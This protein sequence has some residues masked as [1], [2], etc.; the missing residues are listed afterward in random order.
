MA[1]KGQ[2]PP[3][4]DL[5]RERIP[6]AADQIGRL[7]LLGRHRGPAALLEGFVRDRRWLSGYDARYRLRALRNVRRALSLARAYQRGLAVSL[8]GCARW[9]ERALKEGARME[10]PRW[11]DPNA[12]AVL[13]ATVH[14]SKGLEYP[15][16]A[17]FDTPRRSPS[18]SLCPSKTLGLAFSD[19]P[20]DL[21]GGENPA[22]PQEAG[23][24]M[25]WE[26][27]LSSQGELEEDMRLFYVAA[28]RA[29]DALWLCGIVGEDK[30]GN[31]TLPR[32]RWTSLALSW[33]ADEEG[34]VWTDVR[35]PEVRYVD[36]EGEKTE[37]P[38]PGSDE[39]TLLQAEEDAF[40]APP[41]SSIRIPAPGL[42]A[43]T[44]ASFS[45]TSFA[46]FEWCPLAWRRRFRQGLDLRWELPDEDVP[47]SAGGAELGTL[48][49]WILARWPS[50]RPRPGEGDALTYWLTDPHVPS[51]LPAYLRD[52]WRDP[53]SREALT[54]W[55]RTFETSEAGVEIAAA[56]RTG[57]AR[58]EA[59]FR[60][61]I[62]AAGLP[63]VGSMD[64]AWRS[65]DAPGVWHVRDYKITLSENAP[66]ELYQAQLAFYALAV[67]ELAGRGE[68]KNFE[69]VDVG[70]VLLRE[71]GV[72][73]HRR[74]FP[75]T[76]GWDG[77]RDRVLEAA[78]S[79]ALGD[80]PARTDRCRECPW[81]K[82][83]PRRG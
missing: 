36:G 80:W 26:R 2:V 4:S 13:I 15:A 50:D 23:R 76:F 40:P 60:V 11:M 30:E 1:R 31:R 47:G 45:A 64:V 83:C 29:Q 25:L 65:A 28:T 3:L 53:E 37:A 79:A 69:G 62:G 18:P 48:A 34:C 19:I 38:P 74:T 35:N 67:R 63:L 72:I 22:G 59:G 73:G 58:R 78:R 41:G 52:V 17:V 16:V 10:E 68:T 24:T 49:H 66:A 56:L 44:L 43:V 51:R 42:G 20:E 71:G 21:A 54:V 9:M 7:G 12:D 75:R 6:E 8:T 32:N 39:G 81:G 5:L 46:L 27:L 33:L 14:A 57:L 55:L 61:R 70:L 82:S 77:L